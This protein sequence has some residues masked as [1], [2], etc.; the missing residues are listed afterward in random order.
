MLTVICRSQTC[1]SKP[2]CIVEPQ[3]ATQVAA[4]LQIVSFFSAPFA[5]RSGGHS[6]NPGWSSI[7]TQGLLLDLGH[8]NTIEL[9][10]DRSFASLGPTATWGDV[11]ATLDAVG[12][13]VPG[14]REPSIGVGG[15]VIGGGLSHVSNQYGLVADNVKTFEVVH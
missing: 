15:L 3:N 7:G 13:V 6:P 12:A 9:S 2:Y 4:T 1:W 10:S 11:Y 8:L 14:G 5:V